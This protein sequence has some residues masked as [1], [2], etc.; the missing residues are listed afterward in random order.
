[1]AGIKTR[2]ITAADLMVQLAAAAVQP[3]PVAVTLDD[4]G[5]GVVVEQD[6]MRHAAEVVKGGDQP[7]LGSREAHDVV[8]ESESPPLAP[9][10]T[11]RRL[12]KPWVTYTAAGW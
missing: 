2:F 6:L 7:L 4:D 3:W 1:M 11:S 5:L 12:K 10:S 8:P 9:G